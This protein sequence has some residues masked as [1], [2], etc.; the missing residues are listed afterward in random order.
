MNR[1]N[2]LLMCTELADVRHHLID[3]LAQ[4]LYGSDLAWVKD[5]ELS[6]LPDREFTP[7]PRRSL[8]RQR[9]WR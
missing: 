2:V 3:L 9:G 4:T 6:G 5:G 1:P 7:A 8:F